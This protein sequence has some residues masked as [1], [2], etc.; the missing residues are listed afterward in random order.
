MMKIGMAMVS[1]SQDVESDRMT[2]GPLPAINMQR[3]FSRD[4]SMILRSFSRVARFWASEP[5]RVS[6]R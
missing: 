5:M 2:E 3:V 6:W 4:Q 1:H